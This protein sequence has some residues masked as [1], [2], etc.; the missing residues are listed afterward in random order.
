MTGEDMGINIK[1]EDIEKSMNE[2]SLTELDK[3]RPLK[4][5]W[6]LLS[7]VSSSPTRG[8]LANL[9]IEYFLNPYG[10]TVSPSTHAVTSVKC[11]VTELEGSPGHQ[12]PKDTDEEVEVETDLVI[13][14]TGY[15]GEAIEGLEG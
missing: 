2:E 8:K 6:K 1:K 5:L 11:R 3:S 15:K 12:K 7:S 4:R 9:S 14:S 13:W 10:Y